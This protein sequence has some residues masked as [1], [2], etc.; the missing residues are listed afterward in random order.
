V[1]HDSSAAAWRSTLFSSNRRR[2]RTACHQKHVFSLSL[3][4]N[5]HEGGKNIRKYAIN[6]VVNA[7]CSFAIARIAIPTN[8]INAGSPN[9]TNSRTYLTDALNSVIAQLNADGNTVANSY[10]YSPY[11]ESQTI[12]VDGTSNPNQYTSRENDNTGLYFYRARYYDPVIKRFINEDP[13]RT[14]A[15]LNF[16][17][18]VDGNPIMLIDPL[19]LA[20][21][22]LSCKGGSCQSGGSYGTTAMYCIGGRYVC[23]SCAVKTLGIGDLP[24]SQQIPI[25]RPFLLQQGK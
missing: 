16:Y 18:Y 23:Q 14:R 22:D 19:G 6:S 1:I 5:Q 8:G 9:S 3:R 25:L 11:G 4:R 12:G 21:G 24:G 13:I 17:Q 20:S 2:S 7:Q 15:G 10:A